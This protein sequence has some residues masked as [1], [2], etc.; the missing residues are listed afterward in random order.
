MKPTLYSPDDDSLFDCAYVSHLLLET[1][2][3]CKDIDKL[4]KK[5]SVII[6]AW[7]Y[8]NDNRFGLVNQGFH[9]DI[10][11]PKKILR[12]IK[13]NNV[14]VIFNVSWETGY[15]VKNYIDNDIINFDKFCTIFGLSKKNITYLI[16]NN[17]PLK[18]IPGIH[19]IVYNYNMLSI[20]SVIGTDYTNQS[21]YCKKTQQIL[22]KTLLPYYGLYYV[23][24]SRQDRI[25]MLRLLDENNVLDKI[26]FSVLFEP[27]QSYIDMSKTLFTKIGFDDYDNFIKKLNIPHFPKHSKIDTKYNFN[28]DM[29]FVNEIDWGHSQTSYF[30]LAVETLPTAHAFITE[31]S[32]KPMSMLQPI[33]VYG[34]VNTVQHLRDMGFYMF[35]DVIDHSYD[36]ETDE[37]QR[38][39]K[40][41]NEVSRL[42]SIDKWPEILYNNIDKLLHN[43]RIVLGMSHT[44]SKGD[45]ELYKRC[46]MHE[47]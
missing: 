35:D 9:Q 31:K 3:Q 27:T 43:Q 44:I 45:I 34:S 5:Y 32:I 11:F 1:V 15:E 33:V 29:Q 36:E 38:L 17:T 10:N 18:I 25:A 16:G 37:I 42:C 2:E 46:A 28:T 40:V 20:G 26:N 6:N 14:H 7:A 23:R 21:E 30:Q 4:P 24:R 13:E 12:D 41:S 19:T 8:L 39:I 22:D 47:Q